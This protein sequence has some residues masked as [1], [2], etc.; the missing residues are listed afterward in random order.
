MYVEVMGH[1][2]RE[3]G[4]VVVNQLE[5]IDEKLDIEIDDTR[6]QLIIKCRGCV[7]TNR[8]KK[9]AVTLVKKVLEQNDTT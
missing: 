4:E 9:M 5:P 8:I 1:I 3:T 2:D 7:K 6:F